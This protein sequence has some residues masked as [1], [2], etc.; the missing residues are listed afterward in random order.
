MGDLGGWV[1]G[2]SV[3]EVGHSG[4]HLERNIRWTRGDSGGGGG[5]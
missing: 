1:S 2:C 3:T 5:G 4:E